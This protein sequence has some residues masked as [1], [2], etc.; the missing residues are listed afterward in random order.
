MTQNL[1]LATGGFVYMGDFHHDHLTYSQYVAPLMADFDASKQPGI[2]LI[3]Y[4]S[5]PH[6]F[7]AQWSR[8]RLSDCFG[9]EFFLSIVNDLFLAGEFTFAVCLFPNG[10]ILFAYD[11]VRSFIIYI[12]YV[13]LSRYR[14]Y[15]T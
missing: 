3:K 1:T 15:L 14:I 6:V 12:D 8:V 10:T 11:S 2:S 13:F 4:V 7:I 9:G 5:N